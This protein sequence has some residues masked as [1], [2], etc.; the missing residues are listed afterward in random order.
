MCP[1]GTVS[2]TVTYQDGF[3]DVNLQRIDAGDATVEIRGDS[4][5][6]LR[7]VL[8]FAP[9]PYDFQWTTVSIRGN[10]AS[11]LRVQSLA[12]LRHRFGHLRVRQVRLSGNLGD[13]QVEFAGIS[14]DEAVDPAGVGIEV[15]G[16][17]V[18]EIVLINSSTAYALDRLLVFGNLRASVITTNSPIKLINV[19][20][21]IGAPAGS[22]PL[23]INGASGIDRLRAASIRATVSTAGPLGEPG[24][25]FELSTSSGG[26]AGSLTTGDFGNL[27]VDALP[28]LNIAGDLDG[29]ISCGQ[30]DDSAGGTV[31]IGGRITAQ[32]VLR[33]GSGVALPMTVGAP[34]GLEGQVII[35][36]GAVG[37]AWSG[38]MTV[39]PTCPQPVVLQAPRYLNPSSTFGRGA[40]GEVPYGLHRADCVPPGGG[41][42]T[43]PAYV[44]VLTNLDLQTPPT[45]VWYGRVLAGTEPQVYIDML[46][47]GSWIDAHGMFTVSINPPGAAAPARSIQINRAPGTTPVLGLYRVTQRAGGLRCAET[48]AATPPDVAADLAYYFRLVGDCNGDGSII[49]EDLNAEGGTDCAP[50][51]GAPNGILDCYEI[52]LNPF[53][54]RNHNGRRDDCP[55]HFCST[56]LDHN[57]LVEPA[58]VS[59]FVSRWYN[60]L[61]NGTVTN[62][63]FDGNGIIQPADVSLFVN[64]WFA[65]LNYSSACT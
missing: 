35:G 38:T 21:E 50:D 4:S 61:V 34:N 40:V 8:V 48:T 20:G 45:L 62:G 25:M 13:P 7:S 57:L 22:D 18:S 24:H 31:S 19:T 28:L 10:S 26:F 63:D 9:A 2:C 53:L 3:Y 1:S 41:S 37:G 49:G 23:A 58:D 65:E 14:A 43:A 47:G 51:G 56:D 15:L 17:V 33:F 54:D 16:D 6:R 39:C 11:N 36:G 55:P 27:S 30:I 29:T 5:V 60:D 64:T 52:F 59:L 46:A 12:S 42:P 44:L 32:A